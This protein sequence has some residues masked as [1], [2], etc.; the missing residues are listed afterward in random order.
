MPAR[1][2]SSLRLVP[3]GGAERL[4]AGVAEDALDLG[5]VGDPVGGLLSTRMV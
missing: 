4:D 3:I 1:S 2:G 5:G